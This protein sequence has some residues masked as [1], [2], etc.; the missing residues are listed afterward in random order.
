MPTPPIWQWE[1]GGWANPGVACGVE[2]GC[3]WGWA[4]RDLAYWEPPGLA[5]APTPVSLAGRSME[6]SGCQP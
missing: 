6:Q 1:V 2:D 4:P 3:P 5:T